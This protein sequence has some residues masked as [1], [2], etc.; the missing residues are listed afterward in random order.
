MNAYSIQL[1]LTDSFGESSY[2]T[3][4]VTLYDPSNFNIPLQTQN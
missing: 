4:R 3:F 2:L 1:D